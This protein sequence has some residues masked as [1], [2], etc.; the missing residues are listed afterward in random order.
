MLPNCL[1]CHLTYATSLWRNADDDNDDVDDSDDH[2][3]YQRLNYEKSIKVLRTNEMLLKGVIKGV[4]LMT[5][6][7]DWMIP[8]TN[9]IMTS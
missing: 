9:I 2:R 5:L 4:Y 3:T 7:F 8:R 6:F 1:M